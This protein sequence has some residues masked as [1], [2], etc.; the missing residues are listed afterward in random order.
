VARRGLRL[1]PIG[2]CVGLVAAVYLTLVVQRLPSIRRNLLGGRPVRKLS[3]A[4]WQS[5]WHVFRALVEW[6]VLGVLILMASP[7]RLAML[8][9][10]G[11]LPISLLTFQAAP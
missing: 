4:V 5:D 3:Y 9:V 2:V 1:P 7:S 8:P 6:R 11:S 10:L